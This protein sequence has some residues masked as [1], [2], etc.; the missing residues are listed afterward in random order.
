MHGGVCALARCRGGAVP[1]PRVQHPVTVT[2]CN[3]DVVRGQ[4]HRQMPRCAVGECG[5]AICPCTPQGH[6]L[7]TSTS[8]RLPSVTLAVAAA[9][10][11]HQ[12]DPA[13][14]LSRPCNSQQQGTRGRHSVPACVR[15]CS[16]GR[17]A[18]HDV[19]QQAS[20]LSARQ[21][22]C[23]AP[24]LPAITREQHSMQ[25]QDH[26][27]QLASCSWMRAPTRRNK[28]QRRARA[29]RNQRTELPVQACA[30]VR[31]V[32]HAGR[33][34]SQ[35]PSR[36]ASP[37]AAPA[38]LRAARAARRARWRA[39]CIHAARPL[40]R[41]AGRTTRHHSIAQLHLQTDHAKDTRLSP[42]WHGHATSCSVCTRTHTI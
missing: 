4:Q 19:V 31:G 42:E 32:Q 6:C 27:A 8:F 40:A 14:H 16:S 34:H 26:D 33:T 2:S 38:Q 22:P 39:A 17:R 21:D 23:T 29:C 5:V 25:T 36:R 18:W 37:T 24:P 30:P 41:P 11:Q 28:P 35:T 15:A 13:R 10:N 3:S 20:G 1:R 7:D 9:T 12:R